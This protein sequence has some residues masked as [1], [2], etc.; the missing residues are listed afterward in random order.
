MYI[1][2]QYVLSY[3]APLPIRPLLGEWVVAS[4]GEMKSTGPPSGWVVL[5]RVAKEP[6]Q[7]S[8]D[9][10]TSLSLNTRLAFRVLTSI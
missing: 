6:A 1:Y 8:I 2:I 10:S 4:G 5:G 9:T 7:I 3:P